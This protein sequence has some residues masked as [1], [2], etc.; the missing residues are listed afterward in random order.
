MPRREL[1]LQQDRLVCARSPLTSPRQDVTPDATFR[2]GA[3][4][5]SSAPMAVSAPRLRRIY[6]PQ[7]PRYVRVLSSPNDFLGP[8]SLG[9]KGGSNGLSNDTVYITHAVLVL[10]DDALPRQYSMPMDHLQ[11]PKRHPHG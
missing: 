3:G 8:T 5:A 6:H 4:G 1:P 7:V 11:G 10:S 9:N 2:A